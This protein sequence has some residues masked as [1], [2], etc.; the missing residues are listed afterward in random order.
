[1]V[2]L[3]RTRVIALVTEV[4]SLARESLPVPCVTRLEQP[5]DVLHFFSL[6]PITPSCILFQTTEHQHQ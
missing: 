6:L 2:N 3:D 1:M 5:A 4:L